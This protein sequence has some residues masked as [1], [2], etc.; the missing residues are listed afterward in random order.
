MDKKE[1]YVDISGKISEKNEKE[2]NYWRGFSE[3]HN[4]EEFQKAKRKEFEDSVEKGFEIPALPPISRRKFVALLSASAAFAAAGCSDYRDK[5]EIIP[6]NKKPEETTIGNP[7]YYAST[8]TACPSLCGIL[9]KTRE[10]RPIKIDGNPDH[11]VS[12]GKICAQGQASVMNL[13]DPDRLREPAFVTG[14]DSLKTIAWQDADDKIINDLKNFTK[15]GKEIAVISHSVQS[16]TQKKLFDDFTAAYPATKFYSYEYIS[17]S[18]IRSAWKKCYGKENLPVVNLDRAKVI[19]SL[20]SD[21]L[22]TEG[23]KVE[24]LRMYSDKREVVNGLDFN[25]L[26]SVESVM[27]L[28]GMN[29]DYRLRLRTDLIEEFVLSL[30]NEFVVKKK[31]SSFAGDGAVQTVLSKY[32]LDAFSKKNNL[33]GEYV[34]ILL[35]DL[36]ENQGSS[37]VSAGWILP[38]SVHIAVN[39]LNEV[40][41]NSK[42]YSN[43]SEYQQVLPLTSKADFESLVAK[44]K[45]GSVGAVIHYGTNPVYQLPGY[46]NYAEALK[47]VPL[48]ISL[49]EVP[50]ETSAVC[51]YVLPVNHD[52][53]SWGDFKARTGIYSL[54]QPVIAPIHKTRQ[55]EAILL[56]WITGNPAGYNETIYHSYLKSNWE[57]NIYTTLNVKPLFKDFW[58]AALHDGVVKSKEKLSETLS[59]KKEAFTS[60]MFRTTAQE[61]FVLLL[62]DNY[63]VGNGKFSNNGWMQELPHPASKIVWD[64]YAAV[65]PD[66]AKKSGINSNDKIEIKAGDKA[67]TMPV[68]VQPGMADNVVSIE[69]GYG[70]T[71]G[72]KISTGVGV[73]VSDI[74]SKNGERLF[75]GVTVSKVAGTYELISTQEH[76]P[77]DEKRYKDIHIK[78][79]IIQEGT[80]EEYKKD[81]EFLYKETKTER[82]AN[83]YT[84]VNTPHEY[85]G[86]KWAMT[87]DLNKCIGC[88]ECVMSCNIE[89]NIPVVGKD[90]VKANREMH[91]LRIDRY[92]AGTPQEPRASF[93][94]MLCQHCDN[95]PCENVCPV[96]ATTHSPDGLNGMAYNRCVGTR[97]CSNNC[98]YKVRRYNFFDFRD[99]V[100]DGHYY[101]E[102]MTLVSNPEVTVRSRGVMEKC[103]F[104]LQRIM[105]GRQDAII[106]NRILKGSDVKTACQEACGA[107]AINF[108]DMNDKDSDFNKKFREHKLSYNVLGEI[109]VRPNVTYIA[110]LK[111]IEEAK[112]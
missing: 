31:I 76:Y 108:G 41:G 40:L 35:N 12:R 86:L 87:I 101:K 6:Y 92:Y 3:L 59:F 22:G 60:D 77:I 18:N 1:K 45:S 72:G 34:K 56:N 23:N 24:N 21:F 65:S 95:A 58:F 16:P 93:Q 48:N 9:I 100:A 98:P 30:L 91:W 63:R 19:L 90:Q 104:C 97:Y 64:N 66:T 5:G 47:K 67:V 26:Y 80:L 78:R 96:A 107:N 13:Y 37:F 88:G 53:E 44:M 10:G 102:P 83:N 81:P 4:D 46:Y 49:C 52:L 27:S 71:S 20:E 15:S 110:K 7:N 55:K 85:P 28:T 43:E 54:Q 36:A 75:T 38:E 111:N 51:N 14:K 73:N 42:I 57:K 109:K 33:S 25:R 105:K 84:S 32:S 103:T 61:G 8:C 29:A 82:D 70:R 69:L 62:T 99:H 68:F 2:V 89:N 94:P 39:M 11:P 112:S 106:E 74:I 50:D 79:H 17:D